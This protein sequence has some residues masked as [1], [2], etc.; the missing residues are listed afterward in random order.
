LYKK[1]QFITES[2]S[3]V[4]NQIAYN[5][6]RCV[7]F[8]LGVDYG[9]KYSVIRN[10]QVWHIIDGFP[11]PSF[12]MIFKRNLCLG[13]SIGLGTK[14]YNE[15]LYIHSTTYGLRGIHMPYDMGGKALEGSPLQI[16]PYV[17]SLAGF[18]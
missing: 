10:H 14:I 9:Q 6:Y 3:Q 18:V 15:G 8:G 7:S 11:C 5:I 2:I 1:G 4:S 12:A 17:V 13:I 16:I